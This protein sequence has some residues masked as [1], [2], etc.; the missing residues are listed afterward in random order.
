MSFRVRLTL[1]VTLA[2]ALTVTAASAVVWVVAKHQLRSQVDEALVTQARAA[3]LG[4][5]DPLGGGFA[6]TILN[7]DGSVDRTTFKNPPA[8][9]ARTIAVA[10][11]GPS[12]GYFTDSTIKGLHVRILV[13]GISDHGH[14]GAVI[15]AVPL[16][17]TDHALARIRFWIF[18]IGGIGVAAAGALAAFVA[19]AALKP[20]RRL[21]AA[22]E[23]VAATGDLTERVD[24]HGN[25]ELGRLAARFNGMLEALQE[26][27]G[28]QRRLVADASH[29]LRT[30]LTAAR[31]NVDLLREGKLP[32]HEKRHALDEASVE[33]D[34]LTS[35][36]SDL[37]ELARGE[38]RKL[39]VE[40]VQL[41]EL[42]EGVVE[43][44]R[45]RAPQATF[46]TSLTQ[47][48]VRIDPVL[49]ERAV[50]NLLD[51]AVKYSPEGAPIEVIVRDGQVT[52]ADHGPGV[53]DE[54]LPRIFDRFYRA[55]ASRSKPGA[56]LG[57]AIVRE[58]AE[59]HGGQATVESSPTGA[60]FT[61]TLPA[62]A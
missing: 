27:V 60:R 34:A 33:L 28:R 45:S 10:A 12:A 31:T 57:L 37:V 30:P 29:E 24:V 32:E 26:S 3:A 1:M 16:S 23:T 6:Y 36:V 4:H 54:D 18:L 38:E 52:V 14:P 7:G 9:T 51:N 2:I 20:I 39:R 55:A 50:S 49:L 44:A 17:G 53:A 46:V 48:R 59:A 13:A 58:A 35:L 5:N 40:D 62:S 11:A 47:T 41:D 43:R 15:T 61:L 8:I 22:A 42:V 56:G 25:D 19:A 21:T